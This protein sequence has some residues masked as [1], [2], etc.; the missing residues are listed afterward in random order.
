[1]RI[2]N[3]RTSARAAFT[4]TEMLIVVAIIVVLAGIGGT[5]LLPR[6]ESAREDADRV[7][8]YNIAEAATTYMSHTGDDTAPTVDQLATSDGAGGPPL[9][10]RDHTLDR[11]G[12]PFSISYQ[13]G[14]VYVQ[15]PTPGKDGMPIGNWK[16]GMQRPQ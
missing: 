9:M 6:L 11:K 12:Q 8:A 13:N 15:S 14:Q 5:I 4:L 1:M 16:K 7:Q 2:R 10:Q 3:T